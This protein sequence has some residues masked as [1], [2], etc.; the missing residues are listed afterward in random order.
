MTKLFID[1][2]E[3]DHQEKSL[4]LI[5]RPDRTLWIGCLMKTEPLYLFKSVREILITAPPLL[6]FSI[7]SRDLSSQLL[8]TVL[9][10]KDSVIKISTKE[11]Q[12][13]IT[14]RIEVVP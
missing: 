2:I 9:P 4:S 8:L 7:G 5:Y 3:I 14:I 6:G 11:V 12:G 1:G 10:V 13:K